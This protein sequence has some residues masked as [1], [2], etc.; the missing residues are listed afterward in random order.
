MQHKLIAFSLLIA[1]ALAFAVWKISAQDK[2]SFALSHPKPWMHEQIK[3]DL[4]HYQSAGN[5]AIAKDAIASDTLK[6]VS[7]ITIKNNHIT[8]YP[9]KRSKRV[10]MIVARLE[11]IAKSEKLPDVQFLLGDHDQWSQLHY[12]PKK[13]LNQ[14]P[15]IFVFA[16]NKKDKYRSY[17]ALIPD[18][19]TMGNHSIGYRRGWHS[20]A[21]E[22]DN[23]RGNVTWHDKSEIAYWRGLDTDKSKHKDSNASPR[24]RLV[25]MSENHPEMIDAKFTHTKYGNTFVVKNLRPLMQ[26]LSISPYISQAD[27]LRYK[28]LVNMDGYTATYPGFLWRLYSGCVTLKQ[29]TNHQ[30][31]FYSIVK[32]WV[33]YVPMKYDASDALKRIEWIKDNDA[34]AQQMALN[35]KLLVE[36][37]L[38]SAHINSYLVELLKI[39]SEL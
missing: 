15:P 27:Q 17:L 39:Y 36:E 7:I 11:G 33:H 18:D 29:E 35:A 9:E 4:A 30:Q 5:F 1:L 12:V 10:Q 2:A 8:T 37:N 3:S 32:P 16:A 31:W 25:A 24:A 34:K 13:I 23:A 28:I 21:A 19:H 22:I 26:M 14:L 38:T 20:I 6:K